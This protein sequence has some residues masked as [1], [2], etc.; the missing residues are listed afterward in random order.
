MSV[1]SWNQSDVAGF[2][3]R[4]PDFYSRAGRLRRFLL[5]SALFMLLFSSPVWA[6][7]ASWQITRATRV[8]GTAPTSQSDR[9]FVMSVALRAGIAL[10]VLEGILFLGLIRAGR[11]RSDD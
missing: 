11:R 7:L 2:R 8:P 1:E 3:R 4:L 5:I 10:V 6:D 9:Q